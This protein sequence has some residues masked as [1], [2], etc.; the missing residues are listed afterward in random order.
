MI[1]DNTA[2]VITILIYKYNSYMRFKS[3]IYKALAY[4][5]RGG[6]N[7]PPPRNFEV[8]KKLGQI[9]SSVEYKSVTT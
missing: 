8:L 9:P 5:G 3:V 1:L 4:P 7:P 6:S 2:Q